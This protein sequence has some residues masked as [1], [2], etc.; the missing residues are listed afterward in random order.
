MSPYFIKICGITNYEDAVRAI[1]AGATAIGFNFYKQSKRY[2]PPTAAKEIAEKIRGKISIVGLFVNEDPAAVR[3]AGAL[4][5][6]T[7]CQ[8][9][10]DED[11]EYVNQF[12]NAIKTFRVNNSLKDVYF[13]DYHA[14]AFLLDAYD[15]KEYG[16][17]GKNFNWL[18]AREAN[19]FGKIIIAGGLTEGNVRE[20]VETVRPWG[21]DV[22]SGVESGPGKKD[23]EKMRL[24]VENARQSLEQQLEL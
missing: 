1:D 22:S 6:L 2:I 7:Y 17:T 5:K 21:V 4:V 9:H 8:F 15:E 20:A 14:A 3:S 24:F 11:P 12:S 19:E 18:L 23:K 13:D 16:G 10:G